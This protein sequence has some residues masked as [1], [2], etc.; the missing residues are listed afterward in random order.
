MKQ[1]SI[2]YRQNLYYICYLKGQSKSAEPVF[3]NVS[4]AQYLIP[5]NRIRHPKMKSGGP[6]REPYLSYRPARLHRLVE[7]I[8]WN[9]YLRSLTFTNSGSD[10]C[11]CSSTQ[12]PPPESMLF[13][14]Y[15]DQYKKIDRY[16]QKIG[17]LGR[18]SDAKSY[19]SKGFLLYND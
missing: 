14:N 6:V 8:P 12:F 5:R 7:S 3:V 15:F 17:E 19:L 13:V 11:F 18:G 4:G 10:L 9:R 2:K 16:K 1:R